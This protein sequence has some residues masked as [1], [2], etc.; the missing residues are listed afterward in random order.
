[1]KNSSSPRHLV[2]VPTI[3][4]GERVRVLGEIVDG[5]LERIDVLEEHRGLMVAKIE[6]LERAS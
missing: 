5:L 2:C 3:E 1:M 6:L 4:I